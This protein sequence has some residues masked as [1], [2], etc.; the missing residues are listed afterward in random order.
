MVNDTSPVQ[1]IEFDSSG[2]TSS[3]PSAVYN[4][5]VT[6]DNGPACE[7]R[8]SRWVSELAE[9]S[10]ADG[11][12]DESSFKR[13]VT[14]DCTRKRSSFDASI[15]K[16]S[17]DGHKWSRQRLF[18]EREDTGNMA[19]TSIDQIM[20]YI[21]RSQVTCNIIPPHHDKDKCFLMSKFTYNCVIVNVVL[22]L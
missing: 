17:M 21:S 22:M 14:H 11:L 6:I 2:K 5:D 18:S 13:I 16:S 20:Q 8:S 9:E 15:S 19:I 4:S 7:Q 1:A 3:L 10:S 12:P